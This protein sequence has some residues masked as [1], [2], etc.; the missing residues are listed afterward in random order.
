LIE[1]VIYRMSQAGA[2]TAMMGEH[3]GRPIV[4][5]I[6]WKAL[7]IERAATGRR[8]PPDR[9]TKEFACQRDPI[10]PMI[11]RRDPARIPDGARPEGFRASL[12]GA[13]S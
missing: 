10:F 2:I 9:S 8:S 12:D 4:R 1:G 13:A 7:E 11:R 5:R 6:G 3:Q